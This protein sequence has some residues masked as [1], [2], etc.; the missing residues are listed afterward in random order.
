[1]RV[2]PVAAEYFARA[3]SHSSLPVLRALLVSSVASSAPAALLTEG[4]HGQAVRAAAAANAAYDAAW[5]AL[6]S[7]CGVLAEGSS[8]R[9]EPLWP[10]RS[11]TSASLL[12]DARNLL[13]SRPIGADM[14][15]GLVETWKDARRSMHQNGWQFWTQWYD[16]ALAGEQQPWPL[17]LEIA[18]QENDFW[19]GSDDEVMSRINEI[20]ERYEA[21]EATETDEEA[22]IE[23]AEGNSPNAERVVVNEQGQFDIAPETGLDADFIALAFE[24]V[25]NALTDIDPLVTGTGNTYAGLGDIA[26]LV[27]NELK[28]SSHR[29]L[30]VYEVLMQAVS[31]V[32]GR[33]K[34]GE[35]PKND[36]AIERFRSQLSNS[37][38]DILLHDAKVKEVVEKRAEFRAKSLT[39]EE[40]K[41]IEALTALLIKECAAQL[42]EEILADSSDITR[43]EAEKEAQRLAAYRYGSRVV[44]IWSLDRQRMDNIAKVASVGGLLA[45]IASWFL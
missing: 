28:R 39:R 2:M 12:G 38:I 31:N 40:R 1:M 14:P 41:L 18:I 7:D 42:A 33:I 15:E 30:L 17:L 23:T 22:L 37:A 43:E 21:E 13:R 34:S 45:T 11:E 29:P 36:E 6:R 32:E 4:G 10:G 35:L 3:G 25:Q 16:R 19:E 26:K 24:R 8:L 5:A 20:V 9:A 44:R 27:G